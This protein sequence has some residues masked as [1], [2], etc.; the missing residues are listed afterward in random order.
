MVNPPGLA[1]DAEACIERARR[2]A[3][4]DRHLYPLAPLPENAATGGPCGDGAGSG[5][6]M[7]RRPYEWGAGGGTWVEDG[8]SG[9]DRAE[10]GTARRAGTV[11]EAPE[12][13]GS[14]PS[15][16]DAPERPVSKPESN[17]YLSPAPRR[18]GPGP[19]P[20]L[21]CRSGGAP[22]PPLDAAH[23]AL[24][25][26]TAALAALRAAAAAREA[27][28]P[29]PSR[30]VPPPGASLSR[31]ADALAGALSRARARSAAARLVA[32]RYEALA[33]D[34]AQVLDRVDGAADGSTD[35][36]DGDGD[37]D[38]DDGDVAS[39]AGG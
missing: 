9:D 2:L 34:A 22:P 21:G 31:L 17:P 15:S 5:A 38:E 25:D 26:A 29:G 8:R 14:G 13:S 19:P 36:D 1:S 39:G 6:G 12:P 7:P 10:G 4:R 37:A 35:A 11:P 24:D 33:R 20:P 27:P 30:W 32:E 23:A 3:R 18:R 28:P 16:P